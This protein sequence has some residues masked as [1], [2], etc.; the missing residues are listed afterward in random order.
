MK[1]Q[2]D[3][4]IH[5]EELISV[6]S[7]TIWDP[8][9]GMKWWH[10]FQHGKELFILQE[11]P[12]TAKRTE[13]KFSPLFLTEVIWQAKCYP[14]TAFAQCLALTSA[15]VSTQVGLLG[16]FISTRSPTS[17]LFPPC[18]STSS[19]IP[20]HSWFRQVHYC[21]PGA[22]LLRARIIIPSE[23][24]LHPNFTTLTFRHRLERSA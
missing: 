24:T 10:F 14:Y 3:L 8:K 22:V 13:I 16:W 19:Y 21:S 2:G 1:S 12:V 6:S 15:S 4:R 9:S 11:R 7:L 17:A 20:W 5:I 23:R 18:K